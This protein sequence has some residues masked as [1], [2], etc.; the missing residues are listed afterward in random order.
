MSIWGRQEL[1]RKGGA[2]RN[3]LAITALLW[4]LAFVATAVHAASPSAGSIIG[5]QASATYT[6]AGGVSRTVT[7][8]LVQTVVQQV[9]GLD[10]NS[11]G[12]RYTPP[13]AQVVFPHTLA[14]TGNGSD[15][16]TLTVAN[17]AGD[18]YDFTGLAIY[19]DANGDGNPDNFTNL[20]GQNVSLAR[21]GVYQ[22]VV[23]GTVPGSA[24]STQQGQLTITATSVYNNTV[25]A[26]NT[27]TAI[28]TNNAV[29]NVVKSMSSIN[30]A[31]PSGAY[32]VTLSYTNTGNN[33]ATSLALTDDLPAGMTYVA[34]SGRWSVTGSTVLTDAN[35]A[36]NQSG[37]VYDYNITTTGTVT[38]TI[39]SVAPGISG[40]LTFQV[41]IDSG[42]SPSTLENTGYYRFNDGVGL[43]PLT[44]TNTVTFVVVPTASVTVADTG[45]DDGPLAHSD[46]DAIANDI[47]E[48]TTAVEG[49]T[50]IFKNV[51]SNTGS[52]TDTYNISVAALGGAEDFP[53]GTT[54][55]LYRADGTNTLLDTNG[56]GIPDTGPL[57]A[58]G[59]YTIYVRAILPPSAATAVDNSGDGYRS[60]LTARSTVDNTKSDTVVNM[61]GDI[62]AS[63]MDLTL[64][65]AFSVVGALGSGA[66]PGSVLDTRNV[67]PNAASNNVVFKLW[68]NNRGDLGDS[69]NIQ[70][71]DDGTYGV[72]NDLPSGWSVRFYRDSD[73]TDSGSD[74]LLDGD[75]TE[76]NS[77]GAVSSLSHRLMWAVVTVPQNFTA[78]T[79][80]LYF[81]ALS[82][83][84]AAEDELRAAIAVQ[85]IESLQLSPNNAAQVYPG[86]AV[87][88]SHTLENAGN[89]SLNVTMSSADSRSAEGW[90][91]VLY[92]DSNSDGVLDAAD[93]VISAAITLTAGQRVTLF[94]KVFAPAGASEGVSNTT[95]L[96]ATAGVVSAVAS[97]V[98]TVIVGDL[99]LSKL[100]AVDANCDGAADTGFVT[101]QVQAAPGGCLLYSVTATNSGVASISSVVLNDATPAFTTYQKTGVG[102]TGVCGTGATATIG[103]I[104]EPAN[105]SAGMVSVNVG[106]LAAGAASTLE[107]CVRIDN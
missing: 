68:V 6:D 89:G 77:T 61:I 85:T 39:A 28:V 24:T 79:V 50:V 51:V 8:N 60:T 4:L 52:G 71:D 36:D 98:T 88:Y 66:G 31:S 25:T 58:G 22:L 20:A 65:E 19:V 97:N 100:Q 67:T 62:T 81:R 27:D 91:T 76:S 102:G 93:T 40:T 57:T 84:T 86:G 42:L 13:G 46:D 11:D 90:N 82:P 38:A 14:N 73:N 21:N 94:A 7:S 47:A 80:G 37:V 3:M 32:T 30:G 63:D 5:N 64:N 69:Y 35:N 34:G 15:S 101:S 29:I 107:F 96:T 59:S 43:T 78:G 83:S 1:H 55:L 103:T 49:S 33:T 72:G 87:V 16:Y 74:G 26:T 54:F 45:A 12:T 18:D 56:D 104:T 70:V 41:N 75:V 23:V 48:V 17:A 92:A 105:G 99:A 95:S 9:A 106:S 10:L 53:A 44:P 2:M